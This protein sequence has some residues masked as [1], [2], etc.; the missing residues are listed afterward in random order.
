ML[1]ASQFDSLLDPISELYERY[2]ASVINDIARRLMKMG[3]SVTETAAWQMQRLVES[4]LTYQNAISEVAK[5]TG[6]SE[7]VL[8]QT[9]TEAGVKAMKFDDA[10]YKAAGL[11]PLPLNLSPA[12]T[13]V[14][15]AGLMKTNGVMRNLTMTT[16]IDAQNMF[17]SAADLAYLQVSSGAMSYDQAIRAAVKNMAAKGLSTIGYAS[18]RKD[19]LDVAMRRT[20]LT[21]VTQTTG[22][23]QMT[24]ADEMGQDL[25]QTS[26]H[27]GARPEHQEWQGKVF[28]RSGTSKTYPD[29]VSSTEYGSITGLCGINCR[30]SFYPFFEGLSE[31]AYSQAALDEYADA[32]VKYNGQDVPMYDATQMQRA[33]ER[34]IRTAKREAGALDAAG[35]DNS[36]EKAKV[37]DLQAQMR[38]FVKQTGLRRQPMRESVISV[39][40][41]TPTVV[42]TPPVTPT[43]TPAP[44]PMNTPVTP[45]KPI[46]T[47]AQNISE[48]NDFALNNLGLSFADF[49]GADI[50][51]ANEWN[52]TLAESFNDMPKLVS[53]I[54]AT[55][56]GSARYRQEVDIL[57]KEFQTRGYNLSDATKY[58]KRFA[59]KTPANAYAFS[60]SGSKVD[61][62]FISDKYG[63]DNF[64]KSI[65]ADVTSG[66]HPIGTDTIKAVCDHEIGHQIDLMLN[67]RNDQELNSLYSSLSSNQ[68]ETGLSR[69]ALKNKKEFIAESWSEFINNPNPRPIA[70]KVGEI[71][72][73]LYNTKYP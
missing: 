3:G 44:M 23:L 34:K 70:Q 13:Q 29:F 22:Q 25:V 2:N 40:S 52:E 43:P 31:N 11:N 60:I 35:L 17:T 16:A 51:T 14:L 4:G 45:Q 21:G 48:A 18:G 57:T 15:F 27:M 67:V 73:K 64:L 50:R 39:G 55:G 59:Y 65:Q 26:A 8:K 71:I 61:G 56:T 54:E 69:Y 19:Q 33:I 38:D 62:I 46:F 9:F 49:A 12:M 7:E 36:V 20:V 58:A 1:T 68:I 32:T 6:Q 28:S 37:K 47:P 24:R 63:Y 66:F 53:Q 10:L 41:G 5:L 72:Q 30:H 42:N